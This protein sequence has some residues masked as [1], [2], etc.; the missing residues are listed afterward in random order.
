MMWDLDTFS[1]AEPTNWAW[2]RSNRGIFLYPE[3]F[4]LCSTSDGNSPGLLCLWPKLWT[5]PLS[6]CLPL[7]QQTPIWT[8]SWTFPAFSLVIP[9]CP[10]SRTCLFMIYSFCDTSVS[11]AGFYFNSLRSVTISVSKIAGYLHV[12]PHF[13]QNMKWLFGLKL[14]PLA[15]EISFNKSPTGVIWQLVTILPGHNF[16]LSIL[17]LGLFHGNRK[18]SEFLS[19]RYWLSTG[20]CNFSWHFLG[21]IE[22]PGA[23]SQ[24]ASSKK[25]WL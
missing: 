9:V 3:K 16:F 19:L 15:M 4:L 5:H 6:C 14:S 25:T 21:V 20:L 24:S 8:S 11:K 22:Q 17:P 18:L 12:W 13:S 7:S 2:D 1:D 23:I 10:L